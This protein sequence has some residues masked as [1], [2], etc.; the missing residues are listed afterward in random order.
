MP[1]NHP[2]TNG[3]ELTIAGLRFQFFTEGNTDSDDTM[4]VWMPDQKV[5]LNNVLWPYPPNIYTPRGALWRDPR[6]WRDATR[7]LRDLQPEMLIG[8][9]TLIVIEC[10]GCCWL[11]SPIPLGISTPFASSRPSR[12]RRYGATSRRS[13]A[14]VTA[15]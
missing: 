4:T 6:A 14:C 2:V 1:V 10:I 5:A 8:Q 13:R 12:L 3:E 9:P 15:R 7:V 11:Q